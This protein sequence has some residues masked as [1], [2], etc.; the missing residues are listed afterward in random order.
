MNFYDHLRVDEQNYEIARQKRIN[1]GIEDGFEIDR[2]IRYRVCYTVRESNK[3][4]T[5]FCCTLA[6]AKHIYGQIL[7]ENKKNIINIKIYICMK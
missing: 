7:N 5:Q 2:E 3:T 4:Y 6:L 1:L